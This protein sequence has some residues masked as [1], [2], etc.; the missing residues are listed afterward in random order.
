MSTASSWRLAVKPGGADSYDDD[1]RPA[2]SSRPGSRAGTRLYPL[3]PAPTSSLSGIRGSTAAQGRPIT[4]DQN[5]RITRQLA[6]PT[7]TTHARTSS[8]P[9]V[10]PAYPEALPKSNLRNRHRSL[11]T[12]QSEST[13]NRSRYS[14]GSREVLV[15]QA[16]EERIQGTQQGAPGVPARPASGLSGLGTGW[17]ALGP[18]EA[19]PPFFVD[20]ELSRRVASQDVPRTAPDPAIVAASR[21]KLK[22]K[23]SLAKLFTGRGQSS[24]TKQEPKESVHPARA[25]MTDIRRS[26]HVDRTSSPAGDQAQLADTVKH[27]S[28]THKRKT[29]RLS[30]F[31]LSFL[32]KSAKTRGK[33][34]KNTTSRFD[35]RDARKQAEQE[36][37]ETPPRRLLADTTEP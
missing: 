36:R 28:P 14:G 19:P 12:I 11:S 37:G 10:Y 32:N 7:Q 13:R 1:I 27:A 21:A 26:L 3:S 4:P 18:I 24:S 29:S 17:V 5:R 35:A 31:G 16:E 22:H 33:D 23:P 25:S 2:T 30:I 20:G 34:V 8:Q 6:P 15:E 9:P